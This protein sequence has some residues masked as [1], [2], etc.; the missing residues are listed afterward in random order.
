VHPIVST[1]S[2]SFIWSDFMEQRRLGNSGMQVSAIG[3][4]CM[5]IGIAD[6]YTSSA[7]R[8]ESG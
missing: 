1:P 5:S 8:D 6:V 2:S 3:L 4:G 7:G